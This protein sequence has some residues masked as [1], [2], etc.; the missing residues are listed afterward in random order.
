MA[1]DSNL[2]ASPEATMPD[3]LIRNIDPSV[4]ALLK[5]RAKESGTSLQFEAKRALEDSVK[6]TWAEFAEVARKSRERTAHLP[7]TD[8]ARLV[9]EDRDSR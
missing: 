9:R 8:S 6:Y 7:Q 1:V 5:E 2:L 3:I 4:V